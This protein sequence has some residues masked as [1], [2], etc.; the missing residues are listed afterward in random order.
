MNSEDPGVPMEEVCSEPKGKEGKD[1]VE[2]EGQDLAEPK[3][4]DLA[5]PEGPISVDLTEP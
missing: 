2:P 3:V 5:E 1:L 4:Q